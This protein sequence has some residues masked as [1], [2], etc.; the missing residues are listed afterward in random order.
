MSNRKW[1]VCGLAAAMAYGGAFGFARAED[2][3]K[4]GDADPVVQSYALFSDADPGPKILIRTRD[5]G[6]NTAATAR[7]GDDGPVWIYRATRGPD[8]VRVPAPPDG[9]EKRFFYIQSGDDGFPPAGVP[10]RRPVPPG[11]F[12]GR[13]VMYTR[14]V[15][16]GDLPGAGPQPVAI[17]RARR[18]SER[19]PEMEQLDEANATLEAQSHELA[20]MYRHA[21]KD[22][23]GD[24]K[25]QLDETVS[26]QFDIRQRRRKLELSRLKDQIEHLYD[27]IQRHEKDKKDISDRRVMGLLGEYDESF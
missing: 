14:A 2:P 20:E 15:K 5:G 1:I 6:P 8:A 21:P 26:R 19:D 12:D 3:A 7:P 4:A 16:L 25:K 17:R 13:N 11:G 18:L 22:K 24:I 27:S 23:R 10:M 9:P